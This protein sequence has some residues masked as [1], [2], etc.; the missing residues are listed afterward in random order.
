MKH[1]GSG[2]R[3]RVCVIGLGY[4]GLPT[5]AMLATTCVDVVGVDVNDGVIA[6]LENGELHAE[7]AG[8]DSLVKAARDSDRLQLSGTPVP[9]DAFIL[10]VPTPATP[11][12]AADLSFV[13]AAA[14][15][16]LGVLR[17]GNLVILESTVPPTTTEHLLVPI[18]EESGLTVER[19]GHG[20]TDGLLVVH[21]PERVIPGSVIR[22]LKENARV[23]GGMSH[24]A[25]EVAGQ[26]YRR[27]VAGEIFFCDA[28]TAEVVKLAENTFRDVNIALANELAGI[29][30]RVG[31]DAW[32]VIRLAN[33]HPRVSL[34]RP[35]PGVG[36]HCISID[37]WFLVQSAPDR[38]RLIR[39]ARHVN[40]DQPKLV[41]QQALEMV[42]DV[43]GRPSVVVLGLA[44]KGGVDDTRES[45]AIE[46]VHGLRDAGCD[47]RIVDPLV[48]AGFD[49]AA[50]V[51]DGFAEADLAVLVADHGE[52][53]E[54]DPQVLGELMR[55][56]RLLDTRCFL[57]H[58]RWSE[59]GFSIQ[60]LGGGH[61]TVDAQPL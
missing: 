32:N 7:E 50:S 13:E 61:T 4:I 59:A 25:C 51:E 52:F 12:H 48:T 49:G 18:L 55:G 28:T 35:G 5:A 36:G 57:D 42:E 17:P 19:D 22:E 27:F 11:E 39:T 58:R 40:A 14:R 23:I 37:P 60:V 8:L 1:V 41:V 53:R 43:A 54:L 6:K 44:Y 21:C 3:E 10:C 30:E 34:H 45:P 31:T 9:A 38:A 2:T 15:S 47:V 26:L 33:H 29:C 16:I 24:N 20:T 46:V 56:K